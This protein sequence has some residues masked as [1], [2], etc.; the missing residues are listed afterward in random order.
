MKSSAL[1]YLCWRLEVW[2]SKLSL[3][4]NNPGC[5]PKLSLDATL[6]PPCQ[7]VVYRVASIVDQVHLSHFKTPWGC[8]GQS[9][10]KE[11]L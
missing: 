5:L 11:L 2:V 8:K 3:V 1:Y 7:M 4:E 6:Q 10:V 9:S